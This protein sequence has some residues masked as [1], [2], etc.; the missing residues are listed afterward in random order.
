M[1]SIMMMLKMLIMYGY[2]LLKHLH[3]FFQFIYTFFSLFNLVP[4]MLVLKSS[5]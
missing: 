5:N 3:F 4:I 2:E 1:I